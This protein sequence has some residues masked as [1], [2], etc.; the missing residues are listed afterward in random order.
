MNNK[1]NYVI[2][3]NNATQG[4]CCSIKGATD[5]HGRSSSKQKRKIYVETWT[6][7]AN[8]FIMMVLT[9]STLRAHSWNVGWTAKISLSLKKCKYSGWSS[10]K[11]EQILQLR[12]FKFVLCLVSYLAARTQFCFRIK[13]VPH[14]EKFNTA[15]VY[16]WKMRR[17]V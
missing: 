1:S 12:E 11:V 13:C 3:G 14:S 15:H 6:N 5:R 17:S 2:K 10:G 9:T 4:Y 7:H 16:V 8:S